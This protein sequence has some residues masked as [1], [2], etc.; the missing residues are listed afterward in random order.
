M[1]LPLFVTKKNK[2]FTGAIMYALGYSFYYLTNHFPYSEQHLLPFTWID[3]NTPL[4]PYSIFIY[5]S[6]YFYF[7]FVY[8]LL[9]NSDNINKYLYSFF[10]L[11]AVSCTFFMIYPT[12][13]PRADYP[14]PTD[15][16]H[17][18]QAT[19]AWLHSVD[20]P[21]N[22]FP[23]LHVSSVYLS[24]LVF[25][26]DGQKKLFWFTFV[27]S[28]FIALSTLT[29]KQHYVA[30]IVSGL[31][32]AILFYRWFHFRQDYYRLYE[33]APLRDAELNS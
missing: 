14:I 32:L 25:W 17:Y 12:V 8:I 1:K 16:P 18:V 15:L 7:A 28:T 3:R 5:I 19:W 31:G 23:S 13:Y 21:G 11:Q 10:F 22:C 24:A 9:K 6:E 26:T 27:W 30:D 29:T 4:V 20:T 2:Y 33:P